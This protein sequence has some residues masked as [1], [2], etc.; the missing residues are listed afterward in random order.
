MLLHT[1]HQLNMVFKIKQFFNVFLTKKLKLKEHSLYYYYK[2]LTNNYNS[3][4]SYCLLIADLKDL[5][6]IKTTTKIQLSQ[7]SLPFNSNIKQVISKYGKKYYKLK[8]KTES[9]ETTI[10]LYRMKIGGY[11]TKL[12]LHFCENKLFYFNY[13]FSYVK[14][15]HINDIMSILEEKYTN[16]KKINIH[17]DYIIDED[18]NVIRISHDTGLSVQY[19]STKNSLFLDLNKRMDFIKKDNDLRLKKNREIL[20]QKL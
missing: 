10:L 15:K 9:F 17:E 19:I 20:K 13:T 1:I 14:P 16:S 5:K 4:N 18:A 2:F 11:K 12:E 6:P 8:Q 3:D 7:N